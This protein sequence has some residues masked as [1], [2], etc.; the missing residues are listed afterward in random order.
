MADRGNP[1]IPPTERDA[2]VRLMSYALELYKQLQ[3]LASVMEEMHGQHESSAD[4][5]EYC[6]AMR[7]ANDLI[8]RIDG[9]ISPAKE[10]K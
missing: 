1:R 9:V 7:K 6:E 10:N 2:N 4:P 3:A 5:C 8:Y